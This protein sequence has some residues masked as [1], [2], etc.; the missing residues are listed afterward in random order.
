VDWILGLAGVEWILGYAGMDWI[1][2][3]T[4]AN[5]REGSDES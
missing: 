5:F 4:L 3:S 2:Q 1:H